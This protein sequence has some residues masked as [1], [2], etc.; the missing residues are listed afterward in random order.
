M[1]MYIKNMCVCVCVCVSV[2]VCVW[3]DGCMLACMRMD[4]WIYIYMDIWY[5]YAYFYAILSIW[6]IWNNHSQTSGPF[7]P[8]QRFSPRSPQLAQLQVDPMRRWSV[9]AKWWLWLLFLCAHMTGRTCDSEK[10]NNLGYMAQM[11]RDQE[12]SRHIQLKWC[13]LHQRSLLQM[14]PHKF[15]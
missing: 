6:I 15:K 14:R 5:M 12:T 9:V 8:V 4:I 1:C 11:P 13:R 10:K 2:F 7:Q 3:M